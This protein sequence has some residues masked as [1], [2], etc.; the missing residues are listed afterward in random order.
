MNKLKTLKEIERIT[1]EAHKKGYKIVATNGCFDIIHVGHVR[2]LAEAK[3]LGDILIVG[4]NSDV[5][6]RA[7]KG[8][9]RPIVSEKERAEVLA[10]LESVDYVFIF[11]EPTPFNWIKKLRPNIHVKGGGKDV[12][13]HP[14]FLN[15]QRVIEQGGGKFVLLKHADG[16]STSKIIEKIIASK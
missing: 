3:K 6:V 4:I 13:N 8:P 16:K 2:N 9:K 1:Q 11:S 15:Q 14:E 10:G 12:R 5:S 7:I